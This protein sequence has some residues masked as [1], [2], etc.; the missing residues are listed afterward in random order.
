MCKVLRRESHRPL[1]VIAEALMPDFVGL[2]CGDPNCVVVGL[3]KDVNYA[4]VSGV[5]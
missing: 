3:K 4:E 5:L 1:L 2:E